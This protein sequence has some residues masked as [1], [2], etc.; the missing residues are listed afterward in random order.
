[1]DNKEVMGWVEKIRCIAGIIKG[2]IP[3][4]TEIGIQL[5]ILF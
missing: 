4:M 5:E 2:D 3:D 1:M